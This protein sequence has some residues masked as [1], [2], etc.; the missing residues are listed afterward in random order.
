M[1]KQ[2]HRLGTWGECGIRW[3]GHAEDKMITKLVCFSVREN[4]F[5]EKNVAFTYGCYATAARR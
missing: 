3:A 4:E 1:K 5:T 2:A